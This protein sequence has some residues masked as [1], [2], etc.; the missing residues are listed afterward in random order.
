MGLNV[1]LALGMAT[2]P[3]PPIVATALVTSR[4]MGDVVPHTPV[5]QKTALSQRQ[6]PLRIWMLAKGYG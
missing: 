5:G 4:L 6:L 3:Y 2:L 1:M